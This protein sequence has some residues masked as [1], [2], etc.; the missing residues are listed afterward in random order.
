MVGDKLKAGW[1]TLESEE[2][3]KAAEFCLH[4][5]SKYQIGRYA[6]EMISGGERVVD[7]RLNTEVAGIKFENPVMVGA[8][9]DKRGWVVDGLYHLGFSGVEVGSVTER[10]QSGNPKPRLYY[11]DGVGLNNFGFNSDGMDAVANYL[12]MQQRFGVTG[13]STGINKDTPLNLAPEAF[14][15]VAQKLHLYADYLA[16]DPSCPNIP[17]LHDLLLPKNLAAIITAIN[18]ATKD[19]SRPLFIKTTIDWS[20]KVLNDVLDVCLRCGVAGIICSN[21]TTDE[22]LKARY[23]WQD[24][25]G[26]LSGDNP[27]YRQRANEQMR[28]IT[29]VTKG[30]G[31]QL[32]GVGGINSAESAIQRI[33][34]G[35]QVVQVVTSI[36][37]SKGRV[38]HDINEGILKY[39]DQC[40]INDVNQLVGIS[41]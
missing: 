33:K 5:L 15:A 25:V 32:V 35:A 38:A 1:E 12:D 39:L 24:K 17:G 4:G 31:L 23:G 28:Y 41:A 34:S 37:Q 22:A 36:R 20:P 27:I 21:S 9:W 6:I 13:V 19:N 30:T 18:D 2:L 11:K 14:A 40:G 10:Q 8:G 16:I 26:A 3:K 29:R 7:S